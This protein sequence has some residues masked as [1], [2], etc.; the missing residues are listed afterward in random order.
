MKTCVVLFLLIFS[1]ISLFSQV[2]T[3]VCEN[4]ETING[5]WFNQNLSNKNACSADLR[6]GNNPNYCIQSYSDNNINICDKNHPSF[7]GPMHATAKPSIPNGWQLIYNDDFDILDRGFWYSMQAG[8]NVQYADNSYG[9][10]MPQNSEVI[11]GKLVQKI[12]RTP[13]AVYPS[14]Y[15]GGVPKL[16]AFGN[17]MTI[18]S[19][20]INGAITSVL[21]IPINS[22]IQGKIKVYGASEYTWPAFWLFGDNLLEIDI[23]EIMATGAEYDDFA[24][25]KILK[26]NVHRTLYGYPE[27]INQPKKSAGVMH[28]TGQQLSDNFHDYELIWDPY[29]IQWKFDGN[30]FYEDFRYFDCYSWSTNKVRKYWRRFPV[31]N[32]SDLYLYN[33]DHNYLINKYFPSNS[34]YAMN[35]MISGALTSNVVDP[36]AVSEIIQERQETEKFAFWLRSNCMSGVN[37]VQNLNYYDYSNGGYSKSAYETGYSI[38]VVQHGAIELDGEQQHA[39]FAATHEIY[40]TNE[41]TVNPGSYFLAHITECEEATDNQR[42]LNS[43]SILEII[44]SEPEEDTLIGGRFRNDFSQ[45]KDENSFVSL[46]VKYDKVKLQSIDQKIIGI[47]LLDLSG[48]LLFKNDRVNSNEYLL[49]D[50]MLNTTGIYLLRVYGTQSVHLKKIWLTFD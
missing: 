2:N 14:M 1:N 19:D 3:G 12:S 42:T 9:I 11:G 6:M 21:A 48:K 23:F 20:Y 26:T 25:G 22:R 33:D 31:Y 37:I 34:E 39:I 18:Q 49:S 29:K 35:V 8:G 43:D 28:Y 4:F 17:P 24:P 15:V 30:L 41:F 46:E 13:G 7:D 36:S 50:L 45:F 47:E 44:N 38:Q 27:S 32:P 40:I 5:S 10:S 16:D